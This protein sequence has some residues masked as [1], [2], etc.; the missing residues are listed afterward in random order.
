MKKE[1]V[2]R[3]QVNLLPERIRKAE[4]TDAN[5]ELI[6][7]MWKIFK[8]NKYFPM[9]VLVIGAGSSYPAAVFAKHALQNELRTPKIEAVTP[10]TAIRILTQFDFINNGEWNPKYD[11]VIGISY[12]GKT[13]DIKYVSELC[14]QRGFPFILVTGEEK[15]EVEKFYFKSDNM[16]IISY[17]NEKDTTGKEKGILSMAST[18]IPCIIFD[19]HWTAKLIPENQ[20]A[21]EKG[22]KFVSELNIKEIAKSIKESPIIHVFYEWNTLPTALDIENKFIQTGIA[23]VILH[24]KKNFSHGHYN[25]LINQNFAMIINLTKYYT[26]IPLVGSKKT[27]KIYKDGYDEEVAR[28]LRKISETK[29]KEYIEIGTSAIMASQWNIEAMTKIPYLITAIDEEL[30]IDVSKTREKI[31]EEVKPLFNYKGR[32]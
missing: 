21:L 14:D 15:S 16:K 3:Q 19:D 27:S 22:K 24:E 4:E 18:L 25:T 30:G 13:E 2:S 10:Q 9:N 5:K 6:T 31:P 29:Q 32:F 7:Y 23:N 26:I 17:Y 11:L 20:K 28:F 12:S 1:F 8:Q